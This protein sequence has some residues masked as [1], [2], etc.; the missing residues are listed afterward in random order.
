MA[1]HPIPP[2]WVDREDFSHD[3]RKYTAS[4][5]REARIKNNNYLAEVKKSCPVEKQCSHARFAVG[6]QGI[7]LREIL[8]SQGGRRS[9]RRKNQVKSFGARTLMAKEKEIDNSEIH[10]EPPQAA[11]PNRDGLSRPIKNKARNTMGFASRSLPLDNYW[12]LSQFL[13]EAIRPISKPNAV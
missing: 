9:E 13:S 8:R 7:F 6:P 10:L 2:N 5:V 1:F 4:S 12:K 11:W 3:V